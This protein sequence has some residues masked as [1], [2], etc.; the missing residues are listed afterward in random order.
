MFTGKL[1]TKLENIFGFQKTSY[2]TPSDTPEQ[3]TLFINIDSSQSRIT[4]GKE[5]AKAFGTLT[6]YGQYEK[7]PF[8]FM[9]KKIEL[10]NLI[11]K[12]K[13]FFYDFEEDPAGSPAR[14][15]N[16]SERKVKF[17]FLHEA[18]FDPDHGTITSMTM[19]GCDNE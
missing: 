5:I 18:Q 2:N 8:G 7:L 15:L 14:F 19:E 4:A 6:I 9:A 12:E 10:A 3:Y 16:I 1:K 17:I 11:D 13:L